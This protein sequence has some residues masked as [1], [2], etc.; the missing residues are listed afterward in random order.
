MRILLRSIQ[1]RVRAEKPEPMA[2]L[3]TYA[4]TVA[5]I[6]QKRTFALLTLTPY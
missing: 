3:Q 6:Q 1:S 4:L 5:A 2:N